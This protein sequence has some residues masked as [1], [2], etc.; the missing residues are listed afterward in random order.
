VRERIKKFFRDNFFSG[1]LVMVP[2]VVSI[3]V[4]VQV[5][6]WLYR[7]LLFLTFPKDLLHAWLAPRVPDWAIDEA[8]KLIETGEFLALL[9]ALLALIAL[10]GMI[11]KI[12]LVRWLF[13]VAERL[14]EKTPLVGIVYSGIKQLMQA[15]FSGKT[16]FSKVVLVPFP[17][18]GV[19]SI[20]FLSREADA[21]FK[22][23]L[24]DDTLF[25]VF[26]PTTPNITTGFLIVA[27]KKELVEL[28]ITV[29]QAFKMIMSGGL[30][31]PHEAEDEVGLKDGLLGKIAAKAARTKQ[32]T[33]GQ[34]RG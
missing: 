19:W 16:S 5:L 3:Y 20:G 31:L 13:R 18:P 34:D 2:A 4:S 7:K 11:T 6:Q 26:I 29:D 1:L 8:V 17:R 33:A 28:E 24:G 15:I 27:P 10:V 22:Q 14:L 12:G 21:M 9:L 25:N 23:L 30:V 32:K